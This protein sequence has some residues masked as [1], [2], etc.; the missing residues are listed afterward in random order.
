[1]SVPGSPRGSIYRLVLFTL[2]LTQL[3]ETASSG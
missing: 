1:M 2:G 3:S